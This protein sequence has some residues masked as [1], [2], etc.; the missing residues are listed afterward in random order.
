MVYATG[1][2]GD[3]GVHLRAVR[4]TRSERHFGRRG[5]I[6]GFSRAARRRLTDRLMRVPWA[7][8]V[9]PD[10]HAKEA[11]A[12]LVTLTYPKEFPQSPGVYKAHLDNFHRA[13]SYVKQNRY[14]AIWRLELQ[15][16]GAPHYHIL[17]T[18]DSPVDR[19]RLSVWVK[20]T[21]YRVVGSGDVKHRAWGSDVRPLYTP[22]GARFALMRYLIKYLGKPVTEGT[23]IGRCWGE[24]G[25]LATVVRCAVVFAT[26]ESWVEFVRRV[27]KWGKWSGYLRKLRHPEGV[28]LF[29]DGMEY[30][31]MMCQGIDGA[32]VFV[33]GS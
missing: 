6:V 31:V 20:R 16:R 32:E 21:W 12:Y 28:R 5:K 10:K 23:E 25:T 14:G 11:R 15:K 18:F 26:Y 9:Q 30:L 24:W 19:H 27:R 4:P 8:I 13:L 1:W 33:N 17:L 7:D 2:A 22:A 3:G 29:V